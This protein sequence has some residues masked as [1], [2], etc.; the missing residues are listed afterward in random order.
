LLAWLQQ[1]VFPAE[2]RFSDKQ[3][4]QAV[5][6][7][8]LSELLRNGPTTAAVYCTVHSESVEAFFEESERLGTRMI[9]GK[10]LM[11][12][13]APDTLRDTAL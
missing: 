9:A 5:A 3:V 13:N 8:F 1:Y 7:S 6:K 4:A 12:R 10:V 2:S 11:D